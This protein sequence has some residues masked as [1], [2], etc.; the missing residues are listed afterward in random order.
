MRI[1]WKIRLQNKA[2]WV[3]AIPALLLVVQAVL[4]LLGID[5][6]PAALNDVLLALLDAVDVLVDGPF[7]LAQKS[8]EL[9]FCG[10]RNQRLI[11][12]KKTRQAGQVT[13][14]QPDSWDVL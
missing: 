4:G 8:L 12:V 3:A 2:F 7:I 6:Q 11:D 1:N 5:W 10:S 9:K 13:L 14:W